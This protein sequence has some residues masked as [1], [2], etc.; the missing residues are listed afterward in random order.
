MGDTYSTYGDST[1]IEYGSVEQ[2]V[3]KI[4]NDSDKIGEIFDSFTDS[5]SEVYKPDNFSGEAS[6]ELQEKF[7]RLKENFNAYRE[8]VDQFATAIRTAKDQTQGTE[9]DIQND[10]SNL[11]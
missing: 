4:E 5:M 10:A 11:G 8:L 7:K 6:D 1:N 9:K 3:Q 2:K